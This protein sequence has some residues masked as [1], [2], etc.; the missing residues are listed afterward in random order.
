M[1]AASLMVIAKS[2]EGLIQRAAQSELGCLTPKN[3]FRNKKKAI[4]SCALKNRSNKCRCE[5]LV[6]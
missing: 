3:E 4:F 6:V 2:R 5:G 1:P